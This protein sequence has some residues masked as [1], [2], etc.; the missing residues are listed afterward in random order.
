MK[1]I[2]IAGLCLVIAFA[3]SAMVGAS[4]AQAGEYGQCVAK[5]KGNYT[6]GN[7]QAVAEKKGIPDHKGN[8]E[9][10]P[11]ASPTCVKQAKAR[12]EWTNETC[13]MHSVKIKVK[14][15][16]EKVTL[17]KKGR[18]EK[19][20]GPGYTSTTGTA[21]LAIAVCAASTDVGEVT[22]LKTDVDTVTFTGCNTLGAKC[23]SEGQVEGTIK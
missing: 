22:G 8:F 9:W 15:G 3:L 18:Y 19:E 16:V 17:T 4:V 5:K 13:T 14:K 20:P 10:V 23:T 2:E 1:R 11:G 6:E 21:T 7:C 12:F